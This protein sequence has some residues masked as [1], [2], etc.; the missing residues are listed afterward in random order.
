MMVDPQFHAKQ[1]A[2]VQSVLTN[3]GLTNANG[4]RKSS[5]TSLGTEVDSLG[6]GDY[7]G[8][9]ALLQVDNRALYS[10]VA[11]EYTE[12]L[13]IEARI[14]EE[15]FL[16]FFESD[17]Y[18]KALYLAN[19]DI[20]S[21]AS[22]YLLRELA[23]SV[24]ENRF[25]NGE[26][27]FRQD[28]S[29][30]HVLILRSGS[31]KLTT[32]NVSKPPQELLD[33]IKPPKDYI[34]EILAE[35]VPPKISPK[36]R[37]RISSSTLLL[38]ASL[39]TTSHATLSQSR[40][41]F[42]RSSSA[43]PQKKKKPS[44]ES[45]HLIMAFRVQEPRLHSSSQLCCLGPGDMLNHI[46][47]I[48]KVKH[49]LFSAISISHTVVYSIDTFTFMQ[50]LEKKSVRTLL[51]L[52]RQVAERVQLWLSR[53]PS[54]VLFKPLLE[55]LQQSMAQNKESRK[56]STHSPEK[57]AYAAVKTLGKNL[58]PG[59]REINQSG[60]ESLPPEEETSVEKRFLIRQITCQE[61]DPSCLYQKKETTSFDSPLPRKY[62]PAHHS[63]RVKTS[64]SQPPQSPVS[65]FRDSE[66]VIPTIKDSNRCVN[67]QKCLADIA[68]DIDDIDEMATIA[69]ELEYRL[70]LSPRNFLNVSEEEYYIPTPDPQSLLFEEKKHLLSY[71]KKL[72][73][74]VRRN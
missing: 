50:L 52:T 48:C 29:S 25:N 26:C 62:F 12:L 32:T 56:P 71:K 33:Q 28:M 55:V 63:Q 4:N 65:S 53:H 11:A 16:P 41:S 15:K 34:S 45:Q 47:A 58:T 20:F 38:S 44:T 31:I 37:R 14:F 49:S 74:T 5:K 46:E 1:L 8:H 69:P 73:N 36:S 66:E 7:F 51:S 3:Q 27:L 40:V 42:K 6:A 35:V 18:S 59:F 9:K 61:V 64:S 57:R 67:D 72:A 23:I 30:S 19:L 2:A 68:S 13:T 21:H 17:L 39:S 54:V 22:P 60:Y 24:K 10:A 70:Q 43:P